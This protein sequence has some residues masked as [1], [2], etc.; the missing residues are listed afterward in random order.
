MEEC[1]PMTNDPA[2]RPAPLPRTAYARFVALSTRWLDNDAY[3]HLNNVVYYSL[4]DT[5]VNQLLIEAGAL[6]VAKG[7]IVGY[8][9]QTHCDFFAPLAFPQRL[10]A[11]VRVVHVGRSSVRYAIG[12][13]AAGA[14][15][16]AAHGHFVHA[17]VDRA[18]RRPAA[19]SGILS[20]TIMDLQ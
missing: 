6:D 5:A 11:G 16:T 20:Q 18:T 7:G 2:G 4:F 9:V 8:V 15:E 14:A 10:E 13:F 17:Y 12:I 3:G 19:L 1:A